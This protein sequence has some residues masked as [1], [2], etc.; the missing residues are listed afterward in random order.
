MGLG[1]SCELCSTTIGG[2]DVLGVAEVPVPEPDQLRLLRWAVGINPRGVNPVACYATPALDAPFPSGSDLAGTVRALGPGVDAVAV[3]ADE[4][5]T[6]QL[7]RVRA[8]AV[9]GSRSSE[10]AAQAGAATAWA[11]VVPVHR[12]PGETIVVF[13]RWWV[14]VL[15]A[16]WPAARATGRRRGVRGGASPASPGTVSSPQPWSVGWLN[17][18]SGPPHPPATG[19]TTSATATRPARCVA[20][21]VPLDRIHTI[22]AVL[23]R[24]QSGGAPLAKGGAWLPLPRDRGAG[25]GG[26]LSLTECYSL[27]QN[28]GPLWWGRIGAMRFGG[29]GAVCGRTRTDPGEEWAWHFTS[30]PA[31]RPGVEG[32]HLILRRQAP[33]RPEPGPYAYSN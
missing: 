13:G 6:S 11:A 17:L 23:R 21:G 2:V 24:R 9:G 22:I 16:Q 28:R 7:G 30:A 31:L 25:A 33:R 12:G 15:S 18:V 14:G 4:V 27:R 10:R 29:S 3:G 1:R 26:L 8:R 32:E 5:T 20:L 19:S